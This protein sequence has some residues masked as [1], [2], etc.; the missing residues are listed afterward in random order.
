VGSK[1]TAHLAS[2]VK[3]KEEEEKGTMK[4]GTQIRLPDGREGTVVY[5]SLIG[6]G[7]KWGLHDPNP[8]DFEGTTGNTVDE[9]EPED[10]LWAP[11]ALLRKPWGGCEECGFSEE[12]CVGDN[13]VVTRYGLVE[14]EEE[15]EKKGRRRRN[16]D[17]YNNEGRDSQ[18]S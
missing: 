9:K 7:I 14:E 2:L 4:I 6:V 13:Y 10:W 12:Q 8:K 11:E 16:N 5:N 1:P 17:D 3:E 15:E 18:G